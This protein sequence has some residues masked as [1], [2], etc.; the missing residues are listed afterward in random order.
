MLDSTSHNGPLTIKQNLP[1]CGTWHNHTDVIVTISLR[2][3]STYTEKAES[4]Q[5]IHW[6]WYTEYHYQK[7]GEVRLF[8][9]SAEQSTWLMLYVSNYS[10]KLKIQQPD[11]HTNLLPTTNLSWQVAIYDVHVYKTWNSLK[12]AR[13]YGWNL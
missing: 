1:S 5:C 4:W 10:C 6:I 9:F 3:N 2:C 8:L 12:M 7:L 13:T 11:N